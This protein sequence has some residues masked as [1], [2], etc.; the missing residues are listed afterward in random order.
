MAKMDTEIQLNQNAHI[1]ADNFR[2]GTYSP[3]E[4]LDKTLDYLEKLD[5]QLNAVSYTHLTLPTNREV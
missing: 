4:L 1:H 5:T 3:T 2:N